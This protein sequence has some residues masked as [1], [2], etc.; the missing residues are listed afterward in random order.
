MRKKKKSK[1]GFIIGSLC[2]AAGAMIVLPKVTEALSSYLYSKQTTDIKADA[3]DDR[4][5]VVETKQDDCSDQA[6]EAKQDDSSDQVAE[7]KQDDCCDQVAEA[8]QDDR[9][10][11]QSDE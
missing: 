5:Q 8:E 1:A 9:K 2:V 7:A 3:D 10:E 4:D 11:E 6:A